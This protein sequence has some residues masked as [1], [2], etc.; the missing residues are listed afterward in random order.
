MKHNFKAKAR[1][2]KQCVGPNVAMS[3]V[4]KV[5]MIATLMPMGVEGCRFSVDVMH[6][7]ITPMLVMLMRIVFSWRALSGHGADAYDSYTTT[8]MVGGTLAYNYMQMVSAELYVGAMMIVALPL[9]WCRLQSVQAASLHAQVDANES[10]VT[11]GQLMQ[12]VAEP[13]IEKSKAHVSSGQSVRMEGRGSSG[14]D[15]AASGVHSAAC[16]S[17]TS[18]RPVETVVA[19]R[20]LQHHGHGKRGVIMVIPEGGEAYHSHE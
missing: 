13:Q 5:D 1:Q 2:V 10:R 4:K 9:Q 12:Q 20:T 6:A 19:R 7:C 16:A 8:S 15:D 17:S 11:V 18:T 14:H 3:W